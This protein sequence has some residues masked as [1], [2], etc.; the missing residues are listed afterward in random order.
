MA[1]LKDKVALVT[2]STSGIGVGIA[3]I[4]AKEGAKVVV[5]GRKEEK[6]QVVVDAIVKDGGE[7]SYIYSDV[8]KPET[9]RDLIQNVVDKYGKLDVLVNNA[10]N[11]ALPDGTIEELTI[12]M[13]DDIMESDLRSVFI[14]TKEAIPHMRQNGKGSIVNIGSMASHAGD[15]GSA[16]Y[17]SAK[18]GVNLLTQSTAVQ[19]GKENIR[20]NCIRPGLIVTPENKEHL[21]KLLTD[22]F[23][24]NILVNRYGAPEDIGYLALYLASDESEYVTGQIMDVDGGTNAHAT[25]V[26]QF[27]ETGSR[28]W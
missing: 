9:I 25:T 2:G 12:E 6:G 27:R 16:A 7:A 1:R 15:L 10:A 26:A 4:F 22:V 5:T 19:Y 11:V 23:M 18:A 17:A 3:K 14:A 24:S 8:T 20:C 28:T 13:W 21:P